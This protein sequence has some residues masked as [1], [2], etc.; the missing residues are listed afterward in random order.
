M[1]LREKI[2]SMNDYYANKKAKAINC[3]E[4]LNGVNPWD[5]LEIYLSVAQYRDEYIFD[6]DEIID[7]IKY[8]AI[9]LLFDEGFKPRSYAELAYYDSF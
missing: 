9:G 3:F 5:F 7:F 2:Y 4:F 1:T 6:N 8:E